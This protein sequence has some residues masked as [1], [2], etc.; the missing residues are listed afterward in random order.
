[1]TH[2]FHL[3]FLG[4]RANQF[5]DEITFVDG[6]PASTEQEIADSYDAALAAWEALQNPPKSWPDAEQFVTEFT[7]PEMA[8]IDLSSDTTIA[9]LRF[10]LS[11]WN[12]PVH[13]NDPRVITGLDALV[14]AGIIS[15]ERKA[16]ILT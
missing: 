16:E 6:L 5:G 12:S 4:R 13:S 11:T 7:L 3:A 8:G 14:S 2:L 1:M 15:A 9:A 10:M